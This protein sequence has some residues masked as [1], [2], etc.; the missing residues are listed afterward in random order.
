MHYNYK[1]EN[2]LSS[3][4]KYIFCDAPL[5]SAKAGKITSI[6]VAYLADFHSK[7]ILIS[8]EWLP[9]GCVLYLRKNIL[10]M[11]P[12]YL[13]GKS[14]CREDVFILWQ[15]EKNNINHYVVKNAHIIV[16]K[17]QYEKFDM[18]EF[19]KEIFIRKKLLKSLKGS[20]TKFYIWCYFEFLN[21]F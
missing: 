21:R 1:N 17:V 6:G 10:K 20:Q 9:G 14:Y 16:D 2:F 8:T 13:N 7:K 4:I 19:L 11:I 18:R 5:F 3:F 12:I 15:E